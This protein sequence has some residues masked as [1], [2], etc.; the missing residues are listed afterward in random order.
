[1][2]SV[3]QV[4]CLQPLLE[5]ITQKIRRD[6]CVQLH[7]DPFEEPEAHLIDYA[8]QIASRA[9]CA[10]CIQT[11]DAMRQ[12][13]C[14]VRRHRTN[15]DL[16]PLVSVELGPEGVQA[17]LS[18]HMEL[19]LHTTTELTVA[20]QMMRLIQL[21]VHNGLKPKSSDLPPGETP[22]L[23]SLTE[24]A[25][26]E[27]GRDDEEEGREIRLDWQL[28]APNFECMGL[29]FPRANPTPNPHL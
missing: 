26:R 29:R 16:N 5:N 25:P 15:S 6:M 18:G 8:S 2:A 11:R 14:F 24:D 21:A 10:T 12:T 13:L 28:S 27:S 23:W 7:S 17:C 9:L 4:F 3:Q 1:M 19:Q 22:L 20:V